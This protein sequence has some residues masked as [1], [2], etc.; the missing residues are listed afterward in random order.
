MSRTGGGNLARGPS[1]FQV[2]PIPI[3]V[4]ADFRTRAEFRAG[5]R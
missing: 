4:G 1:T 3:L 5:L 2:E